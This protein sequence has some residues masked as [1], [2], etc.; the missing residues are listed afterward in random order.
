MLSRVDDREPGATFA[1]GNICF[2]DFETIGDLPILS[3]GADRYSRNADA[4]VLAWAIGGSPVAVTAVGSF[5]APLAWADVPNK[6][7]QFFYRA[8]AGETVFCAHNA[9]FD[10][11]IWNN[12]TR[13]FPPMLP[14]MIIDSRV[15][16]A[17]AG[18]P[19]ALDL[20]S[21][22]AGVGTDQMKDKRGKA[23]IKLFCLPESTAT[24]QSHPQE[25][26]DFQVYAAQDIVAMRELFLS[27]RQLPLAEW[28]EYWAA[29]QI[30][31]DGVMIDLP[32][33]EAA[34]KMALAA[35]RISADD[36][37]QLTSGT[38][39]TVDQVARIINWLYSVLPPAGRDMLVKRYEEFDEETG[40]VTRPKKMSLTRDRVVRLIAYLEAR[41]TLTDPLRAALRVLQ[42][43]LYGGSKTPAKFSKLLHQHVDGVV[44]GQYVFNG[45]MQTG[46]FSARGV[47]VHNLM[48]DASPY[49]MDAIDALVAGIKPGAFAM[50]GDD[51]PISRKL[52]LLI[53]PAFTADKGCAF[54]WG[55]WANIEA[56]LVPWL[57]NDP[58]ADERLDI[59]RAVDDGTEKFD[60]YTR[61]A[62]D[63]SN[64]SLEEAAQKEVRQRGKVVELACGFG[65]STNALLSMAASYGI[66]IEEEVASAFVQKWREKNRWATR[67]WGKHDAYASYGLWG[68]LNTAMERPGTVCEAGRVS[69]VYISDYLGGSLICILPSGRCLTYRNIRE[70][71]VDVLDDNDQVIGRKREMRFSRDMSRVKLW[72]GLACE[73]VVQAAAADLLRGT[74]VRLS[75]DEY[76]WMPV[77]LHTHD[78]V[79][80]EPAE[81]DAHAAAARLQEL[82]ERGFSWTG[83]LPIAADTTIGRWYSK[84]KGSW[85]L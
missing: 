11:S 24:P 43:R 42:I 14:H 2:I 26:Q 6:L 40:E 28:K 31:D 67:F 78:E 47:Q 5:D 30:N 82:M 77:A 59:F 3:A 54:V 32:L 41:E 46:R 62:A 39:T 12:A 58:E 44:R 61:T 50:L 53:R 55:D 15:Q 73:N 51:T 7:Q 75:D 64:V 56:R 37:E 45:A 68:A 9:F 35:Q 10:R 70:D 83:G 60:I 8:A 16:A 57:A 18:L 66:H 65:G 81:R 1:L 19:A 21:R 22:Y 49:E 29:E 36:L 79:L 20:A 48:R 84:S 13:G 69:Y 33:V 76:S 71:L 34:A 4:V 63:L 25:W 38:V 85:G 27:T 17:A 23:L 72:P 74:L 80:V 52:S